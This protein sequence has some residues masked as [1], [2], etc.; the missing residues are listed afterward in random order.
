MD[1]SAAVAMPGVHAVITGK[2]LPIYFGIIP[3]TEDE[4][5]LCESKARY[6][7]DAIAAVAADSE[8]IAEE[9]LRAIR[10]EY[11][12]LPAVTDIDTAL[13]HPEWQVNEKASQGTLSQDVHLAFGP[14]DQLLPL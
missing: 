11:E 1:A 13:E 3:W 12:P 2:D 6:V 7:G 14:A 8:L 5:A 10:V 4:Q 9:A